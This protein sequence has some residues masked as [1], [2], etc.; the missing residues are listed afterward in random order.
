MGGGMSIEMWL[1][2]DDNALF[3]SELQRSVFD[4]FAWEP[5]LDAADISV[6][7]DD[8]IVTLS[9][10]VKSYP[11][12]LEAERAARRVR[13]VQAVR[14]DLAVVPPACNQ[15]SDREIAKAARQVLDSNV[16]VPRDAVRATVTGG[17]VQLTGAVSL[18]ATRRAA[19]VAVAQ[20]VGVKGVADGITITQSPAPGDL[21]ASLVTALQR[22]ASLHADNI[23]VAADDGAVVLHG[24]VRT[25]A[26]RDEAESAVWAL[27]GVASVRV[28]LQVEP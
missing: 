28:E 19:V 12:K 13:G 6:S 15:R 1:A 24:C 20:L 26:E 18:D 5:T 3:R 23:E 22:C 4:E 7:V 10:T 2:E 21:K 25:L 8:H 27:P 11:D 9:G 17:W 16:L 14:N